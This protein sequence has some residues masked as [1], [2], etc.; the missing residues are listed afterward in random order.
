MNWNWYWT[1]LVANLIPVIPWVLAGL[2]GLG[3]VSWSPLGRS[4]LRHLKDRREEAALLEELVVQVTAMR[5]DLAEVTERLDGTERLLRTLEG[6]GAP[7]GRLVPPSA[8][9]PP[10]NTPH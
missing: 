3:A 5:Q 2:A 8:P 1:Q 10:L 7:L 9:P 6:P 4:L